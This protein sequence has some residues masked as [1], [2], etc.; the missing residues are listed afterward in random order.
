MVEISLGATPIEN[1]T[2]AEWAAGENTLTID[3]TNGSESTTYTVTV[4]KQ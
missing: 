2:A 1:G 4:T 3:V